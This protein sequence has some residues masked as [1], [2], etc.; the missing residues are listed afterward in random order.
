MSQTRA[1]KISYALNP[2]ANTPSA[3]LSTSKTHDFPISSTNPSNLNEYY[4]A[5]RESLANAKDAVGNELT[6]WRD[7]V[8][9]GELSKE[10]KPPKKGVD[11]DDEEDEEDEDE[12]A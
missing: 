4:A 7:A 2:P 11:L 1:I 5:L 9:K 6:G 8:G 3:N 10:P 12:E